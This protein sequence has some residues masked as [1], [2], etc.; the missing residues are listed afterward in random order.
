MQAEV[1]QLTSDRDKYKQECG[2]LKG[3]IVE[4][5][6]FLEEVKAASEVD[7]LNSD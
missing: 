6:N 3:Q 1:E 4:N 5:E 7:A 2:Q